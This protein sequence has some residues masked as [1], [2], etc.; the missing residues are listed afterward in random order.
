MTG[1][2]DRAVRSLCTA[3]AM[4]ACLSA[5]ALG[6]APAAVASGGLPRVLVY[7]CRL[8]AT[9]RGDEIALSL[10]LRTN[11]AN[12]RW[13][14]R[15]VHEGQRVLTTRGR[16]DGRGVLKARTVVTDAPGRDEVRVRAR[17]LMPHAVCKAATAV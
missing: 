10:R 13:R 16:T 17:H 12:D 15:I 3:L 14:I 8:V 11:E 2:S 7:R 5:P 9:D 1:R 6:T 4:A